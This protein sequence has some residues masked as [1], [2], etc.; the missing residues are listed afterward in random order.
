MAWIAAV[1]AANR[2]REQEETEAIERLSADD[3][4]NRYEYKILRSSPGAFTKPDRTSQ[5]LMEQ[6]LFG[7]ELAEKIDD[8]RLILVRDRKMRERDPYVASEMDPYLTEIDNNNRPFLIFGGFIAMGVAVF[9]FILVMLVKDGINESAVPVV[10]ILVFLLILT[11][12]GVMLF[13]KRR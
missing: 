6:S 4:E 7:W 13:Y 1:T 3:S 10:S 8:S 11:L 2:R 9:A 12:F 5:V